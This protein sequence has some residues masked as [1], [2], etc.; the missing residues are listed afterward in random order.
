MDIYRPQFQLTYNSPCSILRIYSNGNGVNKI[1]RIYEYNNTSDDPDEYCKQAKKELEEYFDGRRTGFDVEIDLS[2]GTI[3]Q[4]AVWNQLLN[5]PFGKTKS[6]GQLAHD[7]NNP[8][9]V[10]A[11]GTANGKNPI[12]IIVPCHRIIGADGSLTGFS[13]GIDLKK[14]LLGLEQSKT[15]GSQISLF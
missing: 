15:V 4:Q 5:I 14:N 8:K 6:Y 13:A 3:F 2:Q 10:R 12:L 9:A 11:V 7:M 1:E